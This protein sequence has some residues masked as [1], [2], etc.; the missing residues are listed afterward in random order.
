LQLEFAVSSF[1][2]AVRREVEEVEK[3]GERERRG[4]IWKKREK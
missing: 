2:F 4:R 3:G 1:E